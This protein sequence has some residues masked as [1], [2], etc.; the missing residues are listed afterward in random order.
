[1]EPELLQ[2]ES[3]QFCLVF[4]DLFAAGGG[5]TAAAETLDTV[6]DE[7][8]EKMADGVARSP[9]RLCSRDGKISCYGD[10]SSTIILHSYMPCFL[11]FVFHSSS[12]SSF[13]PASRYVNLR[14][15][16]PVQQSATLSKY[17]FYS[18]CSFLCHLYPT[19]SR[20]SFIFFSYSIFF[21]RRSYFSSGVFFVVLSYPVR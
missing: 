14:V 5:S 11:L 1:M 7:S 17:V 21:R 16:S 19:S 18:T 9:S 8:R 6:A 15:S 4:V 13:F 20:N 3:R 12:L 2:P 10:A